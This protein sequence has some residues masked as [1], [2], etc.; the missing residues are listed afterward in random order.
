[1]YI[2]AFG[3][4]RPPDSDRTDLRNSGACS[5]QRTS[6]TWTYV[7]YVCPGGYWAFFF[8][9]LILA[10]HT[11]VPVAACCSAADDPDSKLVKHT[12]LLESHHDR[13][14]FIA[15]MCAVA[16]ST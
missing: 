3:R 14:L 10:S 11:H 7:R 8:H 6:Y 9:L 2:V 5:H 13:A 4:S 12:I 15:W 16:F 1:M